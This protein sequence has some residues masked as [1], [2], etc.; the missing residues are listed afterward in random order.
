ML[1]KKVL[2]FLIIVAVLISGLAL[3]VLTKNLPAF[4]PDNEDVMGGDTIS[5]ILDRLF[6]GR[7]PEGCTSPIPDRV[8]CAKF[9]SVPSAQC[10]LL[11][12]VCTF[13]GGDGSYDRY[14]EGV[15]VDIYRSMLDETRKLKER[16]RC[17]ECYPHLFEGLLECCDRPET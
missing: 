11:K 3:A 16:T 9:V 1:G 14:G 8:V 6:P 12:S 2:S 17:D 5:D 10:Q 15:C 13:C 7:R 4:S